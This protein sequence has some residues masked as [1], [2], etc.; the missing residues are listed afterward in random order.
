M[1]SEEKTVLD[2]FNTEVRLCDSVAVVTKGL[3]GEVW[4]IPEEKNPEEIKIRV[5]FRMSK[6]SDTIQA[7]KENAFELVNLKEVVTRNTRPFNKVEF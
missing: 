4:D 1:K 7:E 6:D 3:V 2:M 5:L